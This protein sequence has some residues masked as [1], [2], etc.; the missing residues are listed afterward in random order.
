M[1]TGIV[2]SLLLMMISFT[3]FPQLNEEIMKASSVKWCNLMLEDSTQI[4]ISSIVVRNDSVWLYK[5]LHLSGRYKVSDVYQIRESASGSY[6]KGAIIGGSIGMAGGLFFDYMLYSAFGEGSKSNKIRELEFV[7]YPTLVCAAIGVL[8]GD[9]AAKRKVLY[10][11]S[12]NL[13]VNPSI[14]FT[15]GNKAAVLATCT[16]NIR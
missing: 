3:A 13:S 11:K 1:K 12:Q 9:V 16:I 5:N 6:L 10:Q 7:I 14:G 4:R 2:Y 15:P 8:V